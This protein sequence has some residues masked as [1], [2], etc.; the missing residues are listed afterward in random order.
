MNPVCVFCD[1]EFTNEELLKKGSYYYVRS[2]NKYAHEDCLYNVASKWEN[3]I[4][5]MPDSLS[6]ILY[7]IYYSDTNFI[8]LVNITKNDFNYHG[9][10]G[11]LESVVGNIFYILDRKKN[12]FDSTELWN[13]D[14]TVA[15]FIYPRL[16]AFS[17]GQSHPGNMTSEEWNKI[18]NNMIYTFEKLADEKY[19]LDFAPDD[20]VKK[21]NKGLKLFAK[22]YKF[23]WN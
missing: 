12:G 2:K 11:K 17:K 23:L 13:L 19:D 1:K 9:Y 21:I 4:E 16:K 22:Y 6:V 18:L 14:Y 15:N 3:T 20:E 7:D 10:A 8:D 5:E